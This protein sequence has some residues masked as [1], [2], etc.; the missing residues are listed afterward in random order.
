MNWTTYVEWLL[1]L[2]ELVVVTLVLGGCYLTVGIDRLP[3]KQDGGAVGVSFQRESTHES[4]PR[5]Y[6]LVERTASNK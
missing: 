2:L 4:K 5:P 1:K 3:D 6:R